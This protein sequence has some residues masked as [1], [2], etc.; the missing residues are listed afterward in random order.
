MRIP[1][2]RRQI[3]GSKPAAISNSIPPQI[4]TEVR[5]QDGPL[6]RTQTSA[7]EEPNDA[8]SGASGQFWRSGRSSA[9]V[10]DPDPTE[11]VWKLPANSRV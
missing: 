2:H 10:E 5:H 6:G 4:P 9:K 3:F 8:S 1:D 7:A 11:A